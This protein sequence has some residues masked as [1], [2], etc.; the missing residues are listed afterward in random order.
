MNIQF[1]KQFELL[2]VKKHKLFVLGE[3]RRKDELLDGCVHVLSGGLDRRRH[4]VPL[5]PQAVERGPPHP[6]H[7]VLLRHLCGYALLP[8]STEGLI[9]FYISNLFIT[10]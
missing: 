5:L 10:G 3:E 2:R 1:L 4:L 9:Y 7:D 8:G 6:R